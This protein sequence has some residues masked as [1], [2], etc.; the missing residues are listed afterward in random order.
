MANTKK[1]VRV[2]IVG[3]GIGKANGRAIARNPRGEV[4][5]LCDLLEERMQAFAEDL[6]NEVTFYTDYKK[7]CKTP[8]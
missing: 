5:A 6:P 7:L 3:M 1:K 4:V 8:Y 2:A